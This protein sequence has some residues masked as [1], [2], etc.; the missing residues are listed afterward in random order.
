MNILFVCTGNISRSY[1]AKELLNYQI[2]LKKIS[3]IN[4]SSAG[5]AG[6]TGSPAD[7]KMVEYLRLKGIQTDYHRAEEICEDH[8]RWAHLIL[9]MEDRHLSII[10]ERWPETGPMLEKLGRYISNDQTEDDI[11]DPY[12]RS[13]YHYRLA[14]SQISAA[15]DNLVQ[16]LVSEGV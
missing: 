4:V 10:R 6:L 14:Q 8:I 13:S 9:V 15:V 12:A 2:R 16:K 3:D 7:P 1:L 11:A 5:T